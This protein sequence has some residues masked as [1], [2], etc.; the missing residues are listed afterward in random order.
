MTLLSG[1]GVG[2]LQLK[3]L[4]S[5]F[6]AICLTLAGTTAANA[7]R[8]RIVMLGDSLTQGYGLLAHEGLTAQLQN[9]IDDNEIDATIV[10]AGVS[11]DTTAGG[12]ARVDWTLSDDID[13]MIVA[14][15]GNDVLR[16]IPPET[17]MENLD[18][19]LSAGASR[20]IKLMIIGTTVPSNFGETYQRDFEAIYPT[21]AQKYDAIWLPSLLAP[22]MA[23]AQISEV[24][25]MYFQPDG[26]HPNAQGIGIVVQE[27]GPLV[28]TLTEQITQTP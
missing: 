16:G 9:W 18:L 24:L 17:A 22:L 13:A 23:R 2:A 20:D 25:Q 21:L 1:Y 8:V 6:V 10:N 26:L 7:E 14:L 3:H 28:A 12:L 11:G 19:I 15:G 5:V 4:S 27:L